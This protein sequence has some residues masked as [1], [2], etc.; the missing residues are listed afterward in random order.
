MTP[1]RILTKNIIEAL[2]HLDMADLVAARQWCQY[3]M[4]N[5]LVEGSQ[6]VWRKRMMTIEREIDRRITEAIG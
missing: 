1:R 4:K 5:S 3:Q 6:P 2:A